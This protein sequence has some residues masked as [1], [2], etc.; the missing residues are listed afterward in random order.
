LIVYPFCFFFLSDARVKKRKEIQTQ[1]DVGATR[2]ESGSES[3]DEQHL[4]GS[5][6]HQQQ[7]SNYRS[8]FP[9]V[10]HL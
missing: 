5:R 10:P 4:P 6:C 9:T 8:M 3:D 1:N 2:D 7:R